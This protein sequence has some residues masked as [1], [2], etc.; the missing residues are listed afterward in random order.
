[1][2]LKG[3]HTAVLVVIRIM[4]CGSLFM[5]YVSGVQTYPSL[6]NAFSLQGVLLTP[7]FTHDSMLIDGSQR[8]SFTSPVAQ[9]QCQSGFTDWSCPAGTRTFCRFHEGERHSCPACG[10]GLQGREALSQGDDGA[11]CSDRRSGWGPMSVQ[12]CPLAREGNPNIRWVERFR[13]LGRCRL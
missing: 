13:A 4:T 11:L 8:L 10:P 6:P 1:M 2:G 3:K 7:Q 5:G 9:Y 12:I